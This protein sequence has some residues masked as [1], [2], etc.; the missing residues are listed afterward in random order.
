[1]KKK[2]KFETLCARLP[3]LLL[4]LAVFVS[5]LLIEREKKQ[6]LSPEEDDFLVQM[7]LERGEHYRYH[8]DGKLQSHIQFS[9]FEHRNQ[10]YGERFLRPNIRQWGEDGSEH[11]IRAGA[12][13]LDSEHEQWHL[14]QNVLY[15][16][17]SPSP[18]I[19][20]SEVL[21]LN[22]T[23]QIVETHLPVQLQQGAYTTHA[24]AGRFLLEEQR[25]FFFGKVKTLVQ[26]KKLEK[27][28]EPNVAPDTL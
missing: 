22:N 13:Y 12:A 4:A 9:R 15:R 5:W 7:I 8:A 24:Q 28:T 3:L 27:S 21:D 26:N 6:Q 16:H 18:L 1:M 10:P 11:R 14:Y 2:I 25:A 20:R 19:L 23:A 17:L